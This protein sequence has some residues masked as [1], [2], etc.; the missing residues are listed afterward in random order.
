MQDIKTAAIEDKIDSVVFTVSAHDPSKRTSMYTCYSD[1][2]EST[3]RLK[4]FYYYVKMFHFQPWHHKWNCSLT[5][6]HRL[7]AVSYTGFTISLPTAAAQSYHTALHEW[8]AK[9]V[10]YY[11]IYTCV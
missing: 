6:F 4:N 1:D 3:A 11:L 5:L 9:E 7:I 10:W 2:I 8:K